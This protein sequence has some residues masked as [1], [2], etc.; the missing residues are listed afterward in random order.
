MSSMVQFIM[1]FVV[2][3]DLVLLGSSRRRTCIQ[4]VAAQGSSDLI[5]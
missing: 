4:I 2:L 1:I 5:G 3:T